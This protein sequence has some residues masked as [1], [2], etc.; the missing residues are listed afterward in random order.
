LGWRP[1]RSLKEMIDSAWESEV[2][3]Y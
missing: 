2:G 1:Q 3:N